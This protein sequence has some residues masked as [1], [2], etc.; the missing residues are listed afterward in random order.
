MPPGS[1][2]AQPWLFMSSEKSHCAIKSILFQTFSWFARARMGKETV[3]VVFRYEV[4][5]VPCC[6]CSCNVKRYSKT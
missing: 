4:F 6:N 1:A 2:G 5:P 3:N